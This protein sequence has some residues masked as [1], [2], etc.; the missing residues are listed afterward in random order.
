[1]YQPMALAE[2]RQRDL[3]AQAQR[4]RQVKQARRLQR[5]F[6]RASRAER[7]LHRALN[8]VLQARSAMYGGA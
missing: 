6:R 1:M 2:E 3:L 8:E 7:N 4:Q 5:A